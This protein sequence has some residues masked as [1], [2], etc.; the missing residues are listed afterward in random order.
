[1]HR[2]KVLIGIS[3]LALLTVFSSS[4]MAR[5]EVTSATTRE[6][7]WNTASHVGFAIND[8]SSTGFKMTGGTLVM[9]DASRPLSRNI[10]IGLRTV[11]SGA[12]S[13][14][15]QFYR[16]G[17]GPLLTYRMSDDWQF[18]AALTSFNETGLTNTAERSY[19]SRGLQSMIGWER[20]WHLDRRIEAAFGGFAAFHFGELDPT[21][22]LTMGQ[23]HASVAQSVSTA[24]RGVSH[25]A[26]AALRLH[27]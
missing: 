4:P 21:A 18:Q 2:C 5:A 24:N 14:S 9:L 22:Q 25:G 12:Q 1:M 27:L 8:S 15:Q 19:R 10:E 13:E 16:L 20:V 3:G 6:L 17:A 11:A 7:S 23:N 26:E